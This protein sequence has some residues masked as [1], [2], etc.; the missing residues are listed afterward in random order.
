MTDDSHDPSLAVW[1]LPSPAVIDRPFRIKVGVTCSAGCA[2]AAHDVELRDDSGV[3]RAREQLGVAPWPGT[4]ALYWT[5]IEVPAPV[6]EGQR[7][8]QVISPGTQ[9]DHPFSGS[10]T[11]TAARPPQHA[12]TITVADSTDRAAVGG[13]QIRLG[14]YRAVSDVGGQATIEVGAG[15]YD[16]IVWKAGYEAAPVAISVPRDTAVLI[17]LLRTVKSPEP[18]WM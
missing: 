5:E 3:P 8:W 7:T 13:V 4:D 17:E 12:V 14:S 9:D 11:V 16:V 2:L 6:S 1:D 15:S 18:Y 10:F